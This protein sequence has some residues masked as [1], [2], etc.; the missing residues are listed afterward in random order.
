MP[1]QTQSAWTP[2]QEG[3]PSAWTPVATPQDTSAWTP[4]AK[5]VASA[6]SSAPQLDEFHQALLASTEQEA[7]QSIV[8]QPM[9]GGLY[10]AGPAEQARIEGPSKSAA[11]LNAR[12]AAY[13][14]LGEEHELAEGAPVAAPAMASI[15]AAEFLP[16][17]FPWIA[18][19][20]TAGAF[21]GATGSLASQARR[22]QNPITLP[23]LKQDAESAGIGAVTA[24]VLGA[25]LLGLSK[26]LPKGAVADASREVL[27]SAGPTPNPATNADITGQVAVLPSASGGYAKEITQTLLR[28]N[29]ADPEELRIVGNMASRGETPKTIPQPSVAPT[30]DVQDAQQAASKMLP[31]DTPIETHEAVAQALGADAAN[32]IAKNTAT[33]KQILQPAMVGSAKDLNASLD[34]AAE[35]LERNPDARM[36]GSISDAQTIRLA[37]NTGLDEASLLAAKSHQA[38]NDSEVVAANQLLE[39]S[40][41]RTLQVARN[42]QSGTADPDTFFAA[43]AKHAEIDDVVANKVGS[44]AGRAL[45][46]RQINAPDYSGEGAVTRPQA[47]AR[48]AFKLLTTLPE[49]VKRQAASEFVK[50]PQDNTRALAK[51]IRDYTRFATGKGFGGRL[52]DM[53][54][55]IRINSLLS[56][57][58]ALKKAA[59]DTSMAILAPIERGLSG[60]YTLNAGPMREAFSM[61]HGFFAGV[62]DAIR[63]FGESWET[64]LGSA[65]EFEPRTF[66]IPGKTGRVVR[67]PSRIVSSV[68]DLVHSL[69]KSGALYAKAFQTAH[70]EG[71]SGDAL[72]SRVAE[73][74]ANPSDKMLREANLF[75][76]ER[77]FQKSMRSDKFGSWMRQ[78]Q[79]LPA[80]RWLVPFLK[81]PYNLFKLGVDFTPFGLP[82][83]IYK[84]A[85]EGFEAAN[86]T[87][88][89]N[90]IGGAA[91]LWGMHLAMQGK[92]SGIGPSNPQRRAAL[93]ATGWQPYSIKIGNH[94]F[95][96][97]YLQPLATALM[98]VGSAHDSMQYDSKPQESNLA[99]AGHAIVQIGKS[100]FDLLPFVDQLAGLSS[101]ARGGQAS[102][103]AI[104]R[105]VQSE[106]GSLIPTGLADFAHAVDRT[107][108]NPQGI[109]QELESRIPG[110]TRRV[111]P[112]VDASGQPIMRP[113]N[114]L[115]GFNPFPVSTERGD[116]VLSE[117]ARL[118]ISAGNAPKKATAPHLGLPKGAKAPSIVLTPAQ[119]AQTQQAE[120]SQNYQALQRLM[121]DPR[122]A[123]L[124]DDQRRA[125]I[126]R[127][128]LQ[129]ERA[130]YGRAVQAQNGWTP[131][132]DH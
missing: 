27:A 74:T 41:D 16:E 24:P 81:T 125:V 49:D 129:A 51:F 33:L 100:E 108:R 80:V 87:L 96:Y 84:A 11:Q 111:P 60:A 8:S 70:D 105:S 119:S 5:P 62:P 55:E 132:R 91:T 93:E 19:M 98:S 12:I 130:R 118:G 66:A 82:K 45:R 68:N 26:F 17:G 25:A 36:R 47:L 79:N 116:P 83:G 115:G 104:L 67:V 43:M 95:S 106:V 38:F 56:G 109:G 103:S 127:L 123:K 21:S 112:R 78:G 22:E 61:A 28:G 31:H 1:P 64:E 114:A 13:A 122:Y 7:K 42:V 23:A 15:G 71:L 110:L 39:S 76:K 58:A 52:M 53:A 50:I 37:Q 34:A 128:R 88:M 124:T 32:R 54:Y 72:S 2:V 40:V 9:H 99:A 14:N 120:Q 86:P 92:L 73:L 30:P 90:A 46:A 29:N 65:S 77:T 94:W 75:A 97:R 3:P 48:S 113:T 107:L 10:V 102:A 35:M 89:R 85:T 117:L 126:K 20:V 4:V 57:G 121:S 63:A 131:V 59:S 101:I 69:Q 6:Q 44:E 18:K